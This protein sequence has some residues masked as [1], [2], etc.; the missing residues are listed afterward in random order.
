MYLARMPLLK[1][2]S[3]RHEIVTIYNFPC[4]IIEGIIRPFMGR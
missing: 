2:S 3:P 4:A 1:T